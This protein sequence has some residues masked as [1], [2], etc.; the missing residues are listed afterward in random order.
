[1]PKWAVVAPPG[2]LLA[3]SAMGKAWHRLPYSIR[4]PG[5]KA[6]IALCNRDMPH[7]LSGPRQGLKRLARKG[8]GRDCAR[9]QER[10]WELPAARCSPDRRLRTSAESPLAALK[11]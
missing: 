3:R 11:N 10:P 6:R 4:A 5:G 9:R 8:G 1:M 2:R 7:G